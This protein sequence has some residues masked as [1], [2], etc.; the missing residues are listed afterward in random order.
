MQ[1][2]TERRQLMLEYLCEVRRTTREQLAQEF[3]VSIRTV[4]RDLL[5]LACS[6]P[7]RTQQGNGGGISITDGY[8]IGRKYLTSSQEDLLEKLAKDLKGDD[9]ITMQTILKRFREPRR[10]K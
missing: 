6:Y 2:A 8:Y 5:L 7:I 10:K 9:Y 4:E 3:D 1:S